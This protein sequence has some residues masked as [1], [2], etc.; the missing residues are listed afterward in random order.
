MDDDGLTS[1]I[2]DPHQSLHYSI[3]LRMSTY[4]DKELI[5]ANVRWPGR[6]KPHLKLCMVSYD[7]GALN[8]IYFN[9]DHI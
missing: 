9:P 7:L 4:Y 1:S 3:I 8:Y 2:T 6:I 5:M